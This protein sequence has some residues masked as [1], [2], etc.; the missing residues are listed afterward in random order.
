MLKIKNKIKPHQSNTTCQPIHRRY[1]EKINEY[2]KTE[3]YTHQT[4]LKQLNSTI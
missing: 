1:K 3:K 4:K 2:F